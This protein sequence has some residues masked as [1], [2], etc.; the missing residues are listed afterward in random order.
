MQWKFLTYKTVTHYRPHIVSLAEG[1]AEPRHAAKQIKLSHM[2]FIMCT[3]QV[4]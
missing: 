3:T 1:T 4:F 2:Y